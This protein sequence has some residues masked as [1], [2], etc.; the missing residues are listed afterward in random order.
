MFCCQISP[1]STSSLT[2]L[3]QTQAILGKKIKYAGRRSSIFPKKKC[4]SVDRVK[5]Y[6]NFER[7]YLGNRSR[8]PDESK[9][10][11]NRTYFLLFLDR[12]SM[13]KISPCVSYRTQRTFI[14]LFSRMSWYKI[15]SKIKLFSPIFQINFKILYDGL[16]E[17][18]FTFLWSLLVHFI[19]VSYKR[20]GL[21]IRIDDNDTTILLIFPFLFYPYL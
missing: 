16:S 18:I 21:R 19:Y 2:D 11:F 13:I 5:F 9:S 15:W 4:R 20:V 7:L 10:D 6:G 14:C 3:Y 12:V 1:R 8:Y 17:T